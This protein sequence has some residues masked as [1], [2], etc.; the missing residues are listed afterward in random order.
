MDRTTS[1]SSNGEGRWA[2]LP[3]KHKPCCMYCTAHKGHDTSPA[4]A[5]EQLGLL[6]LY[7]MELEM[8]FPC[9]S[10]AYTAQSA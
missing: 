3:G 9:P 5:A 2:D 8:S 1:G 6:V 7:W 4:L 10:R